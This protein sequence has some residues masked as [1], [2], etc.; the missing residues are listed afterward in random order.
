MIPSGLNTMMLGG[1]NVSVP[2]AIVSVG[3]IVGAEA[4]TPINVP[5]PP[6]QAGDLL[7]IITH[8]GSI[9][10]TGWTLT[11]GVY[12]KIASSSSE[13]SATF[14]GRSNSTQALPFVVRGAHPDSPVYGAESPTTNITESCIAVSPPTDGNNHLVCHR[15][16][17][18]GPATTATSAVNTSLLDFS[19]RA[20]TWSSAGTDLNILLWAGV[21]QVAGAVSN[22]SIPC[23]GVDSAYPL[24]TRTFI[25]RST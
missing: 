1:G 16:I 22:S 23:T 6:H 2:P 25:I 9:L 8:T 7:V 24:I 17:K 13:P 3:T 4:N 20:D 21:K 5:M 14:N 10:S 18:G 12:W 19:V 15:G 11:S